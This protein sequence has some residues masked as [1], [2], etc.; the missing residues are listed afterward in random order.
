M[1]E[2]KKK[3]IIIVALRKYPGYLLLEA[4]EFIEWR[5]EQVNNR[6]NEIAKNINWDDTDDDIGDRY[7]EIPF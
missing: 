5:L 7:E 2:K 3:E 1:N 4:L 6:I